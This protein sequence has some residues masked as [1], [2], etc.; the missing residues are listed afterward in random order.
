MA[1]TIINVTNMSQICH[2]MSQ[3]VTNLSQNVKNTPQ[4]CH[5]FDAKCLKM[6]QNVTD[7]SQRW[8]K[9]SQN[10]T[11]S[12][13]NGAASACTQLCTWVAP[14]GAGHG[15]GPRQIFAGQSPVI[16]WQNFGNARRQRRRHRTIASRISEKFYS[17]RQ[18]SCV[19]PVHCRRV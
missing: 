15:A 2:K 1:Q 9:M 11:K 8:H 5:K 12:Q 14:V 10:V 4:I 3:N 6:I 18:P 7:M 13:K 17:W 16:F 19:L